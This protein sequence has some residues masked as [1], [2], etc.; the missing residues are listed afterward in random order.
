M[1][2]VSSICNNIIIVKYFFAIYHKHLNKCLLVFL[3]A[4]FHIVCYCHTFLMHTYIHT[5]NFSLLYC[6]TMFEGAT[7]HIKNGAEKEAVFV[8]CVVFFFF[9]CLWLKSTSSI[10]E[11]A[12][13]TKVRLPPQLPCFCGNVYDV[14]TMRRSLFAMNIQCLSLFLLLA[15]L[16]TCFIFTLSHFVLF[17]KKVLPAKISMLFTLFCKIV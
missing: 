16:F 9:A 17:V 2:Q 8:L 4:Y 5:D 13:T 14:A 11:T 10:A 1:T 15:C 7:F 6:L 12:T 3:L